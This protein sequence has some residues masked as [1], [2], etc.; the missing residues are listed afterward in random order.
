M[1]AGRALHTLVNVLS[2]VDPLVA[3][4]TRA[5]VRTIHGAGVANGI[6]MARIRGARIVQMAQQTRLSRNAATNETADAINARRPIEAGRIS[7]IVDVYA[8]IGSSPPI[9]AN[10]RIAADCVRARR[11]I[12]AKRRTRQ[13]F[14]DVV[15]TVFT[16]ET[17]STFATVRVHAVDAFA[18]I[19]TQIARTVVDIFL[20]IRTFE[21]CDN[22]EE[23]TTLM[24]SPRKNVGALDLGQ[25]MRDTMAKIVIDFHSHSDHSCIS[26]RQSRD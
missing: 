6:G 18:T 9:H 8:A 12:L 24:E 14:V 23:K 11:T 15:L 4:S 2:A 16:R 10:A 22:A 21:T 7:A 1:F 20:T 19:L 13:A 26:L 5:R 17:R 3:R 25:N